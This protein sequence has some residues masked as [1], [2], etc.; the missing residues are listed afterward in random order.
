MKTTKYPYIIAEIGGNHNGDMQLAKKMILEAKKCGA[1]AVKFQL[2]RGHELVTQRHLEE[3]DSGKVKLENVSKW[4]TNELG[5]KNIFEQVEKFSIQEEEHISLFEYA[6]EIGID[7][8]STAITTEGIDFLVDQKVAFLKVASCDINNPEFVEYIISKGL[9]TVISV[10]LASLGEIEVIVNLIPEKFK[11]NITFLHCV[12][13]YPPK[14]KI[15]NLKF[16]QTLKQ[17][18]NVNVGYSDH[19]LGYSIPLAAVTLGANI[20]EKH[21]TMDKDMPGWDHKVSA[22]PFDLKIIC[23]ESKR[24]VD[25]LGDGT[26]NLD[27]QEVSKRLKF[28][29][30][31]VSVK[32]LEKGNI[33][34]REDI[35]YKRPGTGIAPDELEY[36]VGRKVN[37]DISEDELIN[38]EDLV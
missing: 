26:R 7:Y 36:V 27:K 9:P 33:I 8:T 19:T 3:L 34:R 31:L 37:K 14:D 16:I 22:D 6:K 17:Y 21:F 20:I 13:L 35:V 30:S 32:K 15:V 10:G 28:R 29:R 2:Y 12:S 38:W 25:S 5:L 24:I 23:T 4:E 18:F 1:D 11:K